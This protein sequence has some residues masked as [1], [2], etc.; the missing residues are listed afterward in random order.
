VSDPTNV[1]TDMT[2]ASVASTARGGRPP[3]TRQAIPTSIAPA[4][5]VTPATDD[6]ATVPSA[7][8]ATT[9]IAASRPARAD[10]A[11]RSNRAASATATASEPRFAGD[12]SRHRLG[13]LGRSES[14]NL[15][16]IMTT[17]IVTRRAGLPDL[18]ALLDDVGA[19]FAS[20][21]AFAPPGWRPPDIHSRRDWQGEILADNATWALLGV[22]DDTPVGHVT[23]RSSRGGSDTPP[24]AAA[25]GGTVLWSR[26]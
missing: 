18:D 22:A 6:H 24:R 9:G 16:G 1:E 19:G 17:R 13:R 20:Y 25:R 11:V 3:P 12:R 8:V 2:N 21:V 10:T 26:A 7:R 14:I 5:M 4:P 15:P 23:W